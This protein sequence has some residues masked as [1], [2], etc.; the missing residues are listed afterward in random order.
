MHQ[1]FFK[2][3]GLSTLGDSSVII[4]LL[5]IKTIDLGGQVLEEGSAE[6][7]LPLCLAGQY[8]IGST[9]RLSPEFYD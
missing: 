4:D 1:Q 2:V 3:V 6:L 8:P 5:M 9:F 7:T